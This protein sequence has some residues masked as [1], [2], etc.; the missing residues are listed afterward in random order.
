MTQRM[1]VV[2]VL[3]AITAVPA[4]AQESAVRF[5]FGTPVVILPVQ[6][7]E[8]SPDGAWPAHAATGEQA[9]RAMDA[10]LEFALAD[11]RGAENWALPSALRRRV[12]RNPIVD[13][14]PDRLAYQGLIERPEA[15]DQIY[16]PLHGELRTL[17][18]LFGTR[19][20]MLPLRL[21]LA[22]A[23]AAEDAAGSC[24]DNAD[25]LRAELLIVL[26][27]I[28]RSAVMWHGSVPGGAGCPESGALLASLAAVVAR[29][30]AE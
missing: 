5:P 29:E 21:R 20:L 14:N 24:R 28:R 2:A 7:V 13:V 8:P 23:Q 4:A 10:E 15:R 3:L 16:E 30:I 26:I 6:S 19:F 11:R 1:T 22:T 9:L 17:A 18:A 27:D 25:R 12:D